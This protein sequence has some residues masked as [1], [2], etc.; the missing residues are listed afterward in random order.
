[1]GRRS[2]LRTGLSRNDVRLRYKSLI[3]PQLS[4]DLGRL[5]TNKDRV[6]GSNVA[7]M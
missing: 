7:C 3:R 4:Y 5:S 1:M 2:K 6:I